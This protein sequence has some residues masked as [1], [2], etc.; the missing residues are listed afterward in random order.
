MTKKQIK[1]KKTRKEFKK[2]CIQKI[3]EIIQNETKCG[4]QYSGCPCNTCFHNWAENELNL[5]P[6]YAHMFWL[7]ILALR[8]DCD[9]QMESLRWNKNFFKDIIKKIK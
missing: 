7:V 4:I 3:I 8:G 2:D 9:D 6:E 1:S 5:M